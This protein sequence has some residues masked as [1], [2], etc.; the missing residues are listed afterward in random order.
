MFCTKCGKE[1]VDGVRFCYSR[2]HVLSQSTPPE[3]GGESV[4]MAGETVSQDQTA[5]EATS[6][7]FVRNTGWRTLTGPRLAAPPA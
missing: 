4:G 2:G 1:D 6:H 3:A 5:K 7:C